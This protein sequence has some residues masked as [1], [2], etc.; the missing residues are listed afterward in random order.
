M[1]CMGSSGSLL[2]DWEEMSD[3][4]TSFVSFKEKHQ[5]PRN[6]RF[7]QHR[8]TECYTLEVDGELGPMA[9]VWVMFI[10]VILCSNQIKVNLIC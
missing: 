10:Y 5:N 4:V 9:S 6:Q 8:I 3:Q 1:L 7:T 2:Q